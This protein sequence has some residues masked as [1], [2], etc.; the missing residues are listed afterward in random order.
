LRI[1]LASKGSFITPITVGGGRGSA[2]KASGT[3]STTAIANT[4]SDAKLEDTRSIGIPFLLSLSR[5]GGEKAATRAGTATERKRQKSP[6]RR[7]E[8]PQVFFA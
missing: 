6:G 5:T 3:A 2:Y 1:T 7:A 4:M 8:S